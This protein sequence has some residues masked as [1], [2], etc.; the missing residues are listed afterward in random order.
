MPGILE[1]VDQAI[2]RHE[3]RKEQEESRE[4]TPQER[5][6]LYEELVRQAQRVGSEIRI[7]IQLHVLSVSPEGNILAERFHVGPDDMDDDVAANPVKAR[8]ELRD[9]EDGM[10]CNLFDT[11]IK[12]EE[13]GGVRVS[14][15]KSWE[16]KRAT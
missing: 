12:S 15:A 4:I 3:R 7:I 10:L 8:R 14:V 11:L 1:L 9:N 6:S 5:L 16:R 2:A 13:E